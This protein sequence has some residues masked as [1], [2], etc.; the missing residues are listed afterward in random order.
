LDLAA[1]FLAAGDLALTA[2]FAGFFAGD[3]FTTAF[4]FL[5]T[6]DFGFFGDFAVVVFLVGAL[7]FA[8]LFLALAAGFLVVFFAT[9]FAAFLGAG[10]LATGFLATAG[11]LNDPDAP[12]PFD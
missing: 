2:F 7:A 12:T 10:F 3:F 1:V 5:A 8:G 9:G 6:F 4:G 11:N